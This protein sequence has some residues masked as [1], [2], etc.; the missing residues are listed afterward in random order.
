MR[1]PDPW[2]TRCC[3]CGA[4]WET[5]SCCPVCEAT[6]TCPTCGHLPNGLDVCCALCT[7]E[8]TE[9]CPTCGCP[10]MTLEGM[11]CR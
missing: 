7:E 1:Q 2:Q 8:A 6:L 11:V 4:P 5:S 3:L 10:V 9:T